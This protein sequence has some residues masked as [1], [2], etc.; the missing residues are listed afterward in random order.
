[1]SGLSVEYSY[2]QLQ[3]MGVPLPAYLFSRQSLDQRSIEGCIKISVVYPNTKSKSV[4][5]PREVLEIWINWEVKQHKVKM[6]VTRSE[7]SDYL[8]GV[9]LSKAMAKAISAAKQYQEKVLNRNISITR[10]WLPI[11]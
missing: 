4:I 9:R 7:L 8:V 11:C 2:R 3:G 10:T 6:K 1:M 5:S